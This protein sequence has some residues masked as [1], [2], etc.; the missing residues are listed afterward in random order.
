M[1]LLTRQN[2]C[3]NAKSQK[4]RLRT[5]ILRLKSRMPRKTKVWHIQN[6]LTLGKF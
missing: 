5:Q 3:L 2:S 6:Y 4:P 1:S